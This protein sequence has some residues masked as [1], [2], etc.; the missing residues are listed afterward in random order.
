[1]TE[2]VYI[3]WLVLPLIVLVFTLYFY[4]KFSLLLA[5]LASFGTIVC[6]IF[7]SAIA[8]YLVLGLHSKAEE[9]HNPGAGV[10]FVPLALVFTVCIVIVIVGHILLFLC[11]PH[12]SRK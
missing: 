11:K 2:I 5:L 4:R 8:T 3:A 10:A 7:I 6:S 1:M 12:T 9:M